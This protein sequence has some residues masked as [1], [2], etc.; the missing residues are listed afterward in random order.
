MRYC[1]S[2]RRLRDFE[3]N[4]TDWFWSEI[5]TARLGY[6][7]QKAD[8]RYLF[9]VGFTPFLEFFDRIYTNG[10]R[11]EFHLSAGVSVGYSF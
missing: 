3:N 9:R 4:P 8:G 6:R 10:Y 5:F 2:G 1:Q 11:A 7:F